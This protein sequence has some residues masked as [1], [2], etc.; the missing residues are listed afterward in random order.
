MKKSELVKIIREEI[1]KL[2]EGHDGW[3]EP[4]G[5]NNKI[6]AIKTAESAIKDAKQYGGDLAK[7]SGVKY[8]GTLRDEDALDRYAMRYE[9]QYIII[10][11]IDNEMWEAAWWR[12]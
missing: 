3:M 1:Q 11:E 6:K 12:S 5:H 4:T 9:G 10:A 7:F 8:A 2:N